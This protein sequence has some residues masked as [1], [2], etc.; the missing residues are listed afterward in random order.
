MAVDSSIE[1]VLIGL[2][3]SGV[4][5]LNAPEMSKPDTERALRYNGVG[6]NHKCVECKKPMGSSLHYKYVLPINL[7]L[8]QVFLWD[9]I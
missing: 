9:T 6:S 4:R 5:L 3:E 1:Q 2:K 8:M 7:T